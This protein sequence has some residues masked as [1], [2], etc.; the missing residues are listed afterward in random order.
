VDSSRKRRIVRLVAA[1]AR[2]LDVARGELAR[3]LRSTAEAAE[4]SRAA[5]RAWSDQA[6]AV[7][8]ASF[9]NVDEIADSRAHLD[10]LRR[11]AELATEAMDRARA[12]E[13]A[14]RAACI[15]AEREVKKVE[16]W[17]DKIE[18]AE[19]AIAARQERV[20]ADEIAA[21]TFARGAT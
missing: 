18:E 6:E 5:Q 7:A 1:R 4:A 8:A 21:R 10:A 3:A 13:H 2:L 15:A 12:H 9:A 11:R 20:A 17:R 16:I 19:R 14:R